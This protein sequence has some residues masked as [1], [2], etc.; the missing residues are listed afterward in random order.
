M[1]NNLE[2]SKKAFVFDYSKTHLSR[3]SSFGKQDFIF[4][5]QTW[6][7]NRT[8]G[9]ATSHM[10]FS[11]PKSNPIKTEKFASFNCSRTKGK[12]F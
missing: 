10:I 2:V 1:S 8:T 7:V 11:Y 3:L 12:K 4:W 5:S 9:T 6:S